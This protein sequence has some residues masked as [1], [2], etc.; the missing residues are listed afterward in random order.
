MIPERLSV[1]VMKCGFSIGFL[2]ITAGEVTDRGFV[3]DATCRAIRREVMDG[4]RSGTVH[5]GGPE[6]AWRS[7]T[8]HAAG[9]G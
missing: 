1:V 5:E 2:E 9:T 4:K 6:L 7:T 3:D 8:V